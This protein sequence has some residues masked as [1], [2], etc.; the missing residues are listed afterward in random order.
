MMVKSMPIIR[1][2]KAAPFTQEVEDFLTYH[3]VVSG[4]FLPRVRLEEM[5]REVGI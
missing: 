5:L 4:N 2:I 3:R 1:E